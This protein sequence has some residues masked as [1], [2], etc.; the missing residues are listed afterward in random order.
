MTT[1]QA[2]A[3]TFL[4][5]CHSHWLTPTK[6]YG[7]SSP[8]RGIPMLIVVWVVYWGTGITLLKYYFSSAKALTRRLNH[9]ISVNAGEDIPT[10]NAFDILWLMVTV[11]YT[12]MILHIWSLVVR[13]PRFL[14]ILVSLAKSANICTDIQWWLGSLHLVRI[15]W[16]SDALWRQRSG[17]TL[18]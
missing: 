3:Y 12:Y 17:S 16:P 13:W 2:Y 6:L 5:S 9:H 11:I 14:M 18:A 10:C 8:F 4:T 7:A 1:Y 15:L